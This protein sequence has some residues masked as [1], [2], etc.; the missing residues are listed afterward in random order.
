MCLHGHGMAAPDYPRA[1]E[2]FEKAARQGSAN[3]LKHL[4]TMYE[5]GLGVVPNPRTA[6]YYY[7]RSADEGSPKGKAEYDRLLRQMKNE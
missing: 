1:M 4:G 5:K 2:L 3:A 7:G 6:L